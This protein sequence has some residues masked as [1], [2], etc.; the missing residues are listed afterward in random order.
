M[1]K[2][3][4]FS[5]FILQFPY[6]LLSQQAKSPDYSGYIEK[7]KKVAIEEMKLYHIPASITLAQGIIESNCGKSP[8][9]VEANNHFGVKCH[10]DWTGETY[11][12][13]DD[14]EQECFRKYANA[15]ESYRDHS[16]FLSKKTRYAAL[17]SLDLTDYTGWAMGLKQAGYATNPEYP[18]LLIRMIELN[19]LN[20]YDDTNFVLDIAGNELVSNAQSKENDKKPVIVKQEYSG[21]FNTHYKMPNPSDYQQVSTSKLGRKV[22]ENNGIPFIFIKKGD[23]WYSIASEFNIYATQVY[24]QNDM[25]ESDKLAIGQIIYLEGK[26]RKSGTKSHVFKEDETMFSISQLYGIK[27][28]LLC[29]YNNLEASDIPVPGSTLLLS[30]KDGLF[31]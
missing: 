12:F 10:K 15:E 21:L 22:Y 3:I 23:T 18:R 6:V 16:L 25:E 28:K 17:F 8:L 7:Y 30:R 9:A 2:I 27:L 19:N 24:R 1:R 26:K 31:Q 20:I 5:L 14:E 4:L 29:K 11:L 13:D